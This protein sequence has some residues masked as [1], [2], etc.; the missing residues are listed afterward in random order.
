LHS[1]SMCFI[2]SSGASHSLH[3]IRSSALTRRSQNRALLPTRQKTNTNTTQSL[4]QE[5]TKYL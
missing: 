5:H 1:R 4:L 2:D 3:G